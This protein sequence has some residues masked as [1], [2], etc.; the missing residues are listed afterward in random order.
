MP[1][2]DLAYLLDTFSAFMNDYKYLTG[3]LLSDRQKRIKKQV[4]SPLIPC[5][6]IFTKICI[7]Q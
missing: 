1:S 5:N 4:D 2:D 3:Y 6:N 7:V